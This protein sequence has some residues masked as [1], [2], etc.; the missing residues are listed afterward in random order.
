MTV[1]HEERWRVEEKGGEGG[2]KREWARLRNEWDKQGLVKKTRNRRENDRER[3]VGILSRSSW[4]SCGKPPT[5][6]V[7][8]RGHQDDVQSH[9]F[10]T[11]EWPSFFECR[12][13]QWLL[14]NICRG[15]HDNGRGRIKWGTAKQ[16]KD[17]PFKNEAKGDDMYSTPN[18]THPNFKKGCGYKA[19]VILFSFLW[20]S[21]IVRQRRYLLF[22]RLSSHLVFVEKRLSHAFCD[23]VNCSWKPLLVFALSCHHCSIVVDVLVVVETV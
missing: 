17:V 2:R 12:V 6:T 1:G 3:A 4:F 22:F 16:G 7:T 9:Q 18:V 19:N 13:F 5:H 20:P 8:Q 23:I 10:R 14:E 21:T 15:L 11:E